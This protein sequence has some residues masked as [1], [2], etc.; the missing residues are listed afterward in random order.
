M[1]FSL[2]RQALSLP[3][4]VLIQKVISTGTRKIKDM[5][6]RLRDEHRSTYLHEIPGAWNQDAMPDIVF[7]M[8]SLEALKPDAET[9]MELASLYAH[10]YFELLGSGWIQPYY[11]RECNGTENI[12]YPP[13]IIRGPEAGS[14]WLQQEIHPSSLPMAQ[15]IWKMTDPEYKPID[16]QR[17]HKSGYRWDG[18]L[19][20]RDI[21]YG[22]QPGADIKVPWELARFQHAPMLAF[23]AFLSKNGYEQ[24]GD[25]S[26]FMRAFR[27]QVIDFLALNPPRRGVNWRTS[28]DIGIRAANIL[29]GFDLFRSI[30]HEWEREF[31]M[32]VRRSMAEH[33]VHI[34]HNR[35]WSA[36]YRGNH[37]LANL[38][39][40]IY[41]ALGMPEN[42][43]ANAC[44]GFAAEQIMLE[45]DLQ[46][47]P[48][49][50]NFEAS[51]P[52]HRLSAECILYAAAGLLHVQPRRLQAV[53]NYKRKL[54]PAHPENAPRLQ[55][56]SG[57]YPDKSPMLLRPEFM[58]KLALIGQA[59][60]GCT[61]NGRHAVQIGD[62]DSGRF[63]VWTPQ[64]NWWHAADAE[65]HFLNLHHSKDLGDKDIWVPDTLDQRTLP[66]GIAA[67][68]HR[69]DLGI[70]ALYAALDFEIVRS[71]A[72]LNKPDMPQIIR[73]L[74]IDLQMYIHPDMPM[75]D[76]NI[77]TKMQHDE[78]KRLTDK[79]NLRK[80]S[81]FNDFGLW[82]YRYQRYA[83]SIRAGSIGQ[84]G[85]GG[86]A[87]NDQLAFCF[88]IGNEEVFADP[89]TYLYTPSASMRNTFRSIMM[90][91]TLIARQQE[92]NLWVEG[93]GD[94]L[95]WMKTE[96]S[97]ATAIAL[98]DE[99]Q[100]EH[101]C[102]QMP[103][104][105]SIRFYE[106]GCDCTDECSIPGTKMILFHCIPGIDVQIQQPHIL[107]L[108]T[109][110]GAII[111]L[112]NAS[113]TPFSVEK[114]VFSRAYGWLEECHRICM[115]LAADQ[116]IANWSIRIIGM[117]QK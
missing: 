34:L 52:Y 46:F 83:V 90:H 53:Q 39:G 51:V 38:T 98:Q 107:W 79:K 45:T 16:W 4:Q 73:A 110:G 36:S 32:L 109:P 89:G 50:L 70:H 81:F 37:Y 115:N 74:D 6:G 113:K 102:W 30:G 96:R 42:N 8:P 95:F 13:G 17:D 47:L 99:W 85:K 56:A 3:P 97:K 23:A 117:Q 27:N 66:A 19:W 80:H 72:R 63:F 54:I 77:Q 15:S 57:I 69:D 31:E 22:M 60:A 94:V 14:D 18:R 114:S 92:Q 55:I 26:V 88:A 67:L 75:P 86:H 62:N 82:I 25:A 108:Q 43:L 44:L 116:F 2:L 112:R 29:A 101:Q 87:H 7:H 84:N 64:G 106:A 105:R 21:R 33:A 58:G 48:D 49:G 1:S 71:I 20:Y 40:L 5:A 104:K 12:V 9:I 24:W 65:S 41:C 10:G 111:E 91:S 35:E 61:L 103:H 59:A 93:S 76:R 28:M 68:I 100:G 78:W 11:N